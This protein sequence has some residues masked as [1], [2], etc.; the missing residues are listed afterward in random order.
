MVAR[1]T[2]L[3]IWIAASALLPGCASDTQGIAVTL[4]LEPT[5]T[6]PGAQEG[7]VSMAAVR[8]DPCGAEQ[9][10]T[11]LAPQPRGRL[12]TLHHTSDASG[13]MAPAQ[14]A[15]LRA[16]TSLGTFEATPDSYCGV[17]VL[18][19]ARNNATPGWMSGKSIGVGVD[20]EAPPQTTERAIERRA[21]FPAPL[22][23]SSS[24]LRANVK[25]TLSILVPELQTA[26][27]Q[28]SV[29]LG[30]RWE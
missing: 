28:I 30:A 15:S 22:S 9:A 6:A 23:L 24:R 3:A 17:T 29:S 11:P 19:A 21:K 14:L 27:A 4:D 2:K 25:L 12:A 10:L 7:F 18:I 20:P 1:G 13:A 16:P 26:D 5:V 8:L